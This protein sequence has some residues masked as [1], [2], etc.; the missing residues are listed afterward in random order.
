MTGFLRAAAS[1][2]PKATRSSIAMI[3][4]LLMIV[5]LHL[6]FE[7]GQFVWKKYLFIEISLFKK[8]LARKMLMINMKENKWF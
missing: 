8:S 3:I 6:L 4:N 1:W 7:Y 2:T 5:K